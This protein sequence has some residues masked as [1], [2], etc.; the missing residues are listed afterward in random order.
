VETVGPAGNTIQPEF[1]YMQLPQI[2]NIV[3]D[4]ANHRTYVVLAPRELS[5]GEIYRAIR[6]EIL[7][8]GRVPLS[9]GETLT[10]RLGPSGDRKL[11][12]TED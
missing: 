9:S 7:K 2:E 4:E 5:D 3:V 8:R 1:K 11:D 12:F 10:I 6:Q